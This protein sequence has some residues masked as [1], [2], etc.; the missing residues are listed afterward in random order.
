MR[1]SHPPDS[2]ARQK[3]LTRR[4]ESSSRLNRSGRVRQKQWTPKVKTGCVTCKIRKVKC[5]ETKPSCQRCSSTGRKCDGYNPVPQKPTSKALKVVQMPSPWELLPGDRIE[6]ESFQFFHSVT[7]PNLAGFFDQGR[8]ACRLLQMSHQY[9]ALWH[10]M[11]AV[12]GAHRNFV[13]DRTPITVSRS[14]DNNEVRFALRQWNKS[15]QSLQTLLSGQ[16]LTKLDRLVVLSICL[17]FTTLSSL[18]GR[19]SQAFVHINSGLK[20]LHHWNLAD[21]AGCQSDEDLDLK[22]LFI[23]FSQLDS[24]ARPYRLKN[25]QWTDK[26]LTPSSSQA[27]FQSLLDA[28]VALEVHFNH[29]MQLFS[30]PSLYTHGPNAETQTKKQKCIDNFTDWDNKLAQFLSTT[31]QPEDK[32]ALSLLYIRR[33]LARVALTMDFSKGEL[34]HDD[35]T[36]DYA[37]ILHLVSE[38]LE[39]PNHQTQNPPQPPKLNFSLATI[40]TEPLFLVAFRCR[41]PTIRKQAM[42]L[43]RRFPGREGICEGMTALKIVEKVIEIEEECLTSAEGACT[44]GRWICGNHRVSLLQFFLVHERQVKTVMHTGE[45]LVLGRSGRELVT[46]YW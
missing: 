32:K 37:S 14:Q 31:P 9:P 33:A 26:Q 46:T 15:I 23:L 11:A 16:D 39:A 30:D 19:Q 38:I 24:Q 27:P 22:M 40:T 5:D 45:D 20:L 13:T 2:D 29:M 41:E 3:E 4:G 42:R 28:C 12:A 21:I 6:M 18:Q 8:W 10:A 34:A 35:F 17:L 7:T 43:L 1:D 25:L 36:Q 44:N